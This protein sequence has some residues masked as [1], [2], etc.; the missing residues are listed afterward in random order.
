M[1]K[2]DIEL[3]EI[4]TYYTMSRQKVDIKDVA[5][6]D[7]RHLTGQCFCVKV[8]RYVTHGIIIQLISRRLTDT[9]TNSLV[10][11]LLTVSSQSVK[12]ESGPFIC[13]TF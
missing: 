11:R 2:F 13:K 1:F 12:N 9:Q 7:I 8:D 4:N 3:Y 10:G 5:R 6:A